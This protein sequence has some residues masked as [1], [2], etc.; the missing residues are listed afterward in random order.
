[1][2]KNMLLAVFVIIVFG[3]ILYS[4]F[5]S[6]KEPANS[7]SEVEMGPETGNYPEPERV[8]ISSENILDLSGQEMSEVSKSIFDENNIQDLDLS[9]NSLTG[10]LPAEVRNLSNLVILNLSNNQF[11]GVPAE[12]GQLS[13]LRELDLSNNQITGLPYELGNL[14]ALQKLDLRG[15]AYS[16]VDLETIKAMFKRDVIVLID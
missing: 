15:N 9:N 11:T 12:I 2:N 4:V 16:K 8:E 14:D 10:A 5:S 1:M 6:N 3:M 13:K 7:K